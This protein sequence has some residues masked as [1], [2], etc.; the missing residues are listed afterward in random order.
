LIVS[1]FIKIGD[2][3]G[4]STDRGHKGWILL[5]MLTSNIFRSI[6]RGAKDSQ[7][8]Q[9]ETTLGD[10]VVIRTLD[11][12][13]PKLAEA[14]AAGK[15]F[16]EV[17]VHFCTTVG[18][19][20]EPYLKYKLKNVILSGYTFHANSAG[21]PLGSEEITLAYTEVEWTYVLI[22]PDTLKKEG[23]VPGKYAPPSG[24]AG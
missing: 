5:D 10:I 23:Q 17:E 11:K 21:D 22:N 2:I 14:C 8:T 19:A 9:G 12:S 3:E 4:Q 13:T 18:G 16:P 15:Q 7:R 24:V 6:P 20:E 1:A